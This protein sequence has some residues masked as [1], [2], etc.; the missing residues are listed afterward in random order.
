MEQH[1]KAIR[2]LFEKMS[3]TWAS[4]DADAYAE[5]FTENCDYVTF[6]GRLLQQFKK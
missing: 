5:L 3:A 2:Q 6:M 1:E 4:G